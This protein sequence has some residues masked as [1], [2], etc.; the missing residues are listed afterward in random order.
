M[1]VGGEHVA[2]PP[3]QDF[4]VDVLVLYCGLKFQR[5]LAYPPLFVHCA[6]FVPLAVCEL[7]TS[8]GKP[9]WSDVIA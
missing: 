3:T 8:S 7:Y 1:R 9:E 4:T 5:W 2:S 6:T